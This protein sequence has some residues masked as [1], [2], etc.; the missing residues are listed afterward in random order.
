MSTNKSDPADGQLWQEGIGTDG[1]RNL[2]LPSSRSRGKVAGGCTRPL[3]HLFQPVDCLHVFV[4]GSFHFS[5]ALFGCFHLLVFQLHGE[6]SHGSGERQW[7]GAWSQ[8]YE[9]TCKQGSPPPTLQ[10]LANPLN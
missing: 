1:P 5:Q 9:L 7:G 10:L 8:N 2:T 3:T 4:S 6:T